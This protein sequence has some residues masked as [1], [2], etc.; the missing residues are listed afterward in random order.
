MQIEDST[1]IGP[2]TNENLLR[3]VAIILDIN[4]E[5]SSYLINLL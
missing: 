1:Q 4:H 3:D 5:K 2:P